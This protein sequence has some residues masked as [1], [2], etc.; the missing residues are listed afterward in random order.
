VFTPEFL[1]DLGVYGILMLISIL[2][3]SVVVLYG[4]NKQGLGHDCNSKYSDS[5]E[6][7]FSARS[8]AFT[9]MTWDFLLFAWQLVD[10][11]RSFFAEIFEKGGSF[12]AWTKRLWKNPFLFWSVTAST[13]LIPPTLYIPVINRVV[14]M[15]SPID[16]EWGVIFIAVGVFFAGAEGY[17]WS[18]RIYFRRT[19]AKEFREEIKDV[20]L[21]VFGRYMDGS[22]N[23]SDSNYDV[24]RKCQS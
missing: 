16:W 11:R 20:E 15:H 6:T 19:V 9:T 23:G 5:C 4:F 7:V 2:G 18:K 12:K 24:E 22:E 10:F 14:F 1:V 8:T 3:S 13:V 17:K 21:Y